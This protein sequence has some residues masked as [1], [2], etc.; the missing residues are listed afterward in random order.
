LNP[1]SLFLGTPA[2]TGAGLLDVHKHEERAVGATR[3][4]E[5]HRL[6]G[7]LQ[8][9]ARNRSQEAIWYLLYGAVLWLAVAIVVGTSGKRLGEDGA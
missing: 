5:F 2:S 7:D 8:S 3:A 6:T 9:V 1:A 4:C